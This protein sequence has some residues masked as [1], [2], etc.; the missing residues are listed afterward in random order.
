MPPTPDKTRDRFVFIDGLRALAALGVMLHHYYISEFQKTF[1]TRLPRF[2]LL[3]F[4]GDTQRVQIFFVISGFVIAFSLRSTVVTA[5]SAFNFI[6]RRQV[7]LDPAY[8]LCLLIVSLYVLGQAMTHPGYWPLVPRPRTILVNFLYLQN[9]LNREQILS[10]SWSLCLEV[11]L[12]LVYILLL[13]LVQRS[14]VWLRLP[15]QREGI[16]YVALMAPLMFLSLWSRRHVPMDIYFITSWCV[17]GLGALIYWTMDNKIS[18][19][20]LAGF[21]A[22]IVGWSVWNKDAH[23]LWCV[24]VASIIYASSLTGGLKTWLRQPFFQYFGRISYSLFLVHRDLGHALMRLGIRLTGLSLSSALLWYV[25][26]CLA[27]IGVAQLLYVS[28]ER[29][30]MNLASRLK[31]RPAKAPDPADVAVTDLLPAEAPSAS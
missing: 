5:A 15:K 25:L 12:Y 23:A 30:S 31:K 9:I 28:V 29:P 20:T 16:A 14:I 10:V 22:G 11:Q 27:S 13:L 4:M 6:L 2:V 3:P 1:D 18:P 21:G 17:F 26:S 7:R 8:W 19:A 24:G